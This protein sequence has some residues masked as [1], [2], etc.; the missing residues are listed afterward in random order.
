MASF[1]NRRA[2]VVG[3]GNMGGEICRAI[4]AD[5]GHIY[6]TYNRNEEAAAKLAAE[7]DPA[8][9]AGYHS[10]DITDET[11]VGTTVAAANE[12]LGGIDVLVITTGY[13]H[14]MRLL[15][16]VEFAQARKTIEIELIGPID[17]VREAV[18]LMIAN[19]Y[20]RIVLVGSDSGKVGSTGEAASSA[21]RGGI[22]AF[23]KALAR[24]TARYD[25][26]VNVVCPGSLRTE[27]KLGVIKTQAERAGQDYDKAVASSELGD[28][29]GVARLLA[30]LA[31]DD[32][33]Y[34]RRNLFTR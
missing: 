25:I 1:Q 4:A 15:I 12:A 31:S 23:S 32:G 2:F 29:E 17:V 30:F 22:I 18:S 19:D 26:C 24:E 3:G 6:F 28:P 5:G 9:L 11:S 34:V 20:G 10:L 21:A 33:D 7:I 27:M 8:R 13:V 14:D 16:D